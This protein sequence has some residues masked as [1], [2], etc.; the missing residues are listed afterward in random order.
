MIRALLKDL[1]IGKSGY[2]ST[3]ERQSIASKDWR[4]VGK[5]PD[6]MFIASCNNR[7]YELIY[8]KS[9]RIICDEQKKENDMVKTWREMNDGMY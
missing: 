5:W 1:L 8:D 4:G 2:I 3:A 7:S 6:V 9:S